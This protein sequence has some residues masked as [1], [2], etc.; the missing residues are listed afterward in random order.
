ML[1]SALILL[2][3]GWL[4]YKNLVKVPNEVKSAEHIFPAEELFDK[5]TQSGFNKDSIKLVLNGGNGITPVF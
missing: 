3:G 2:A 1:V 4:A 5:M